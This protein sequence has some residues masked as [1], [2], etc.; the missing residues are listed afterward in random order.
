MNINSII[1]KDYRKKD[2]FVVRI[3][4][5]NSKPISEKPKMNVNLYI[6]EY[7][8]NKTAFRPQKNKP[9]QSQFQ[10]GHQPQHTF[11]LPPIFF[12]KIPKKN[13]PNLQETF[14]MHLFL[15]D[16]SIVLRTIY[17]KAVYQWNMEKVYNAN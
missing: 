15:F 2:D 10:T 12:K 13:A 1:T 4:K 16:N 11:Y 9:N 7:Y 17:R 14:N 8:E 6:I 3:N 5:P